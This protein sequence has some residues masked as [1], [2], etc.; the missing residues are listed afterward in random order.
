[1][2]FWKIFTGFMLLA[3]TFSVLIYLMSTVVTPINE[4]GGVGEWDI[5]IPR[6]PA[7][8][9]RVRNPIE[10]TPETISQGAKLYL[11]RASCYICHGVSGRGDGESGKLLNP[12]PRDFGN[13]RFQHLRT[14]GELFWVIVHG[15]PGTGMFSYAPRMISEEEAWMIIH[16]LRTLSKEESD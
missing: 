8:A 6:A 12:A 15:S 3:G 16:Y 13:A 14:D 11:G 7:E 10:R 2:S 5:T 1:M 9:K 4:S